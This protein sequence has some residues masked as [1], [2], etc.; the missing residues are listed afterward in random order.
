MLN[1]ISIKRE[2][3]A[4]ACQ[5]RLQGVVVPRRC[6]CN[7]LHTDG[8]TDS[9]SALHISSKKSFNSG[10]YTAIIHYTLLLLKSQIG[11]VRKSYVRN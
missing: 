5:H 9:A 11:W 4:E 2:F 7:G 1:G 6:R 8:S 10:L 3:Y